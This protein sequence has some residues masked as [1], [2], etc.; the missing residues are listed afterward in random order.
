MA[1]KNLDILIEAAPIY[2]PPPPNEDEVVI[3]LPELRANTMAAKIHEI[4]D[5]DL[6][7]HVRDGWSEY[8]DN[9]YTQVIPETIEQLINGY[10]IRCARKNEGGITRFNPTSSRLKDI[11]KQLSYMSEIWIPEKNNAP[12]ILGDSKLAGRKLIAFNNCL[13]DIDTYETFS[14]TKD[15]YNFTMFEY[16]YNDDATNIQFL[17]FLM[18]IMEDDT[19]RVATLLEFL[20]YA[21]DPNDHKHQSF[22][23]CSGE[24]SNG[25]GTLFGVTSE[26]FGKGTISA[27]GLDDLGKQENLYG[28][29]GKLLNIT[30]ESS[31]IISRKAENNLKSYTGEDALQFRSLYKN[32]FTAH[33]TAKMIIMCNDLILWRDKTSAI[34]RRMLHI[35]FNFTIS[36]KD[37]NENLR[38]ELLRD[39]AG[40]M[41][42]ILDGRK[43]LYK[44][45]KFTLSP[46]SQEA[47]EAY[48]ME[49]DP[50]RQF[51]VNN[52]EY[53][54][55]DDIYM[56]KKDMYSQYKAW[57]DEGNYKALNAV[58]FGKHVRR[59]FKQ[60]PKLDNGEHRKEG[61]KPVYLCLQ[62]Q[63]ESEVSTASSLYKGG[64]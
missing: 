10:A 29:W 62:V 60:I 27:V 43:Q 22:L 26:V 14:P 41:K 25:K 19:M 58:H 39:K 3:I 45:G 24:G 23:L 55:D 61:G 53:V 7:F 2:E 6:H 28:T 42:A 11:T 16:D 40:I 59:T 52:Y 5:K 38:S 37:R 30:G 51:L 34:W 20:G 46:I 13:L 47:Q 1:N 44:N 31:G 21:L 4:T 64:Y 15:F 57:C 32:T 49:I 18:E 33:P 50:T 9:R 48:R 17:D 8:R 35:P 36:I 12:C 56:I 54:D 63:S